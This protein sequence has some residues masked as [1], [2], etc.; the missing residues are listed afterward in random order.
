MTKKCWTV[1]TLTYGTGALAMLFFWLLWGDFAWSMK[2][3]AVGSV[4]TLMVKSFGV[5]DF[6]Y[7]LLILSFPNFTNIFLGPIV[8]YWSDRHCGRFGRRIPFL[9]FTVPI[10]VLGLAGLGLTPTLA[11]WLCE[12]VGKELITFHTAAL[13]WFGLFWV[14]FDF[15]NTLASVLFTALV[16]DVVPQQFLGRFFGLFRAISLIA[17]VMF[18]YWLMGYAETH[19]MPI[20]LC[21]ALLYAVGFTLLL[22][23]VKEG[24]Y[25]PVD[26]EDK[27]SANPFI[28]FREYAKEC[29]S[30]KPYR[31]LLFA[32]PVAMLA[33]I[34]LNAYGIFYAKSLDISMDD[35]GKFLAYT[36]IISFL[37][38]YLLGILS[39]RFHPV[40]TGIVTLALY[41]LL[42]FAGYFLVHGRISFAIIFIAHGVLTGSLLTLTASYGPRLFPRSR[43][44]QFNSAMWLLISFSWML[45]TPVVGKFLDWTG[46]RYEYT[47]LLGGLLA[48]AGVWMLCLA[49]RV[50]LQYGGDGGYR[51]P[52]SAQE[53]N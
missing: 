48:V 11:Q 39:D 12:T 40:R 29:F 28:I 22:V 26:P 41:G 46:N 25:P 14:L 53:Q 42:C 49:H 31:I 38:S 34:P 4:A 10:I 6:V 8:S 9:A 15:G 24:E 2:D 17:G 21:L 50:Y 13:L 51:P 5:S 30:L 37:L 52:E 19:A 45:M 18:N 43:F 36:Y 47:L 23:N 1:G 33:N 32:L 27:G 44:A 16:N 20:F 3:R 7:G 35:Y